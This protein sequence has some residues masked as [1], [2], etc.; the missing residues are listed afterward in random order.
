MPSNYLHG[1]G[2]DILDAALNGL[3]Q[4]CT[5][6]P[7]PERVYV[8]HGPPAVDGCQN[9]NGQLSVHLDRLEMR[10]AGVQ[11]RGVPG[12]YQCQVMPVARFVVELFRCV[13]VP[14]DRG[15][16][17]TEQALDDSAADLLMDAWSIITFLIAERAS[18]DLIP[19]VGCDG[20]GI[21]FLLPIAPQGGAAGWSFNV[22]VLLSDEGPCFGS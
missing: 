7:P 19:G 10:P 3:D 22:E 8:S 4:S 14:N 1:I 21:G 16:P 15:V 5:G 18:G 20:V 6:N 9:T 17:P 12:G 13:P 11:S 2:T